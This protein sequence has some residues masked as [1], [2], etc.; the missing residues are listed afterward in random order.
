[1]VVRKN[2]FFLPCPYEFH[3][4]LIDGVQETLRDVFK[5]GF[6]V[7]DSYAIKAIGNQSKECSPKKISQKG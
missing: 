4:T 1:M 5:R 6:N 7:W 2:R 3:C